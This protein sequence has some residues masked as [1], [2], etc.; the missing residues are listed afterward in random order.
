MVNMKRKL[1]ISMKPAKSEMDKNME[2]G[3]GNQII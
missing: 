3:S 1:T 2:Y